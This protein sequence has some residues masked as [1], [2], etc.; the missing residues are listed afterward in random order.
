ML[1]EVDSEYL[2]VNVYNARSDYNTYTHCHIDILDP[3]YS[4]WQIRELAKFQKM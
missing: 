1:M 2:S 4:T 3:H